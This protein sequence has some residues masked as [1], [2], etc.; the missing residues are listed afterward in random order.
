MNERREA[1]RG[2]GV[3]TLSEIYDEFAAPPLTDRTRM[4]MI[5]LAGWKDEADILPDGVPRSGHGFKHERFVSE[6][7]EQHLDE[8]GASVRGAWDIAEWR[9]AETNPNRY[10]YLVAGS[11]RRHPR[12]VPHGS[13]VVCTFRQSQ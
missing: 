10:G 3:R 12:T 1:S 9:S 11:R 13:R 4:L 8:L 6:I 5:G 2:H 7:R